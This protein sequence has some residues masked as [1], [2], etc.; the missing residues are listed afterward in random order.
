MEYEKCLIVRPRAE[1]K[2]DRIPS[3]ERIGDSCKTF[4]DGQTEGAV[5][6]SRNWSDMTLSPKW[7]GIS[8]PRL[9]AS[10]WMTRCDNIFP[11]PSRQSLTWSVIGKTSMR[12]RLC[13]GAKECSSIVTDVANTSSIAS[14]CGSPMRVNDSSKGVFNLVNI[15]RGSPPI[16]LM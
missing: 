9:K 7:A 6:K 5:R 10:A 15:P 14:K 13:S 4:R 2:L 1:R 8:R 12:E 16:V 3:A 11:A